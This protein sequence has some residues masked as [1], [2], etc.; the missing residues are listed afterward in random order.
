DWQ[1][2][3][4]GCSFLCDH[5]DG[6]NL[7]LAHH[8]VSLVAA[9]RAPWPQLEAYRKR[10]GWKFKWV[11]SNGSDFNYD[12]HVTSTPEE[13]AKGETFYNYEETK[14]EGDEHPG[15]SVFYK[16]RKGDIYHT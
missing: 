12:Y 6:A 15:L 5:I 14:T 7:H 16:D 1:E 2:G 4:P 11:S 3:C 10:M 9:S 13:V 8:D